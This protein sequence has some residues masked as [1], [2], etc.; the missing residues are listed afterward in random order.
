ME[1]L[2][3]LRIAL[4]SEGSR[5]PK[6]RRDDDARDP[7]GPQHEHQVGERRNLTLD[8]LDLRRQGGDERREQRAGGG[9][10]ERTDA[11]AG[12]V[13]LVGAS[14]LRRTVVG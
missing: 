9:N 4:R 13:V 1:R 6:A 8:A 10:Q 12:R 5:H 3:D 2:G 14:D 7:E 11:D